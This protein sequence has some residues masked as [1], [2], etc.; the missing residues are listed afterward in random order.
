MP[1][2]LGCTVREFR[3]EVLAAQS[4]LGYPPCGIPS[5]PLNHLGH[6]DRRD[7]SFK[8]L[9]LV[10]KIMG[11]DIRQPMEIRLSLHGL[12][13]AAYASLAGSSRFGQFLAVNINLVR[14]I[15]V[16]AFGLIVLLRVPCGTYFAPQN[17]HS[18]ESSGH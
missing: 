11:F 3:R 10:E 4:V 9:F 1:Q 15:V 5:E 6:R 16:P 17:S 14:E 7:A 2:V 8:S 18:S 13:L 12:I